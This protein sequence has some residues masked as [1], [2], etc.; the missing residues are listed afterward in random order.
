MRFVYKVLFLFL[1]AFH[2]RT[3]TGVNMRPDVWRHHA[4][5]RH[6]LT[7]LS[8]PDVGRLAQVNH[9]SRRAV[10]RALRAFR[11]R[12]ARL[13]LALWVRRHL[14]CEVQS[15]YQELETHTVSRSATGDARVPPRVVSV[16][17]ERGVVP[18][19]QAT[20]YRPEG[21]PRVLDAPGGLAVRF[22]CDDAAP[23]MLTNVEQRGRRIYSVL[24]LQLR[25]PS[26]EAE[27]QS[28][29]VPLRTL[30]YL[31]DSQEWRARLSAA[32]KT[33][34]ERHG[35]MC[36]F[37]LVTADGCIALELALPPRTDAMLDVYLVKRIAAMVSIQELLERAAVSPLM[38]LA[39]L[40]M[41]LERRP[42]M[43]VLTFTQLNGDS[44]S[45]SSSVRI[46][47]VLWMDNQQRQ[48]DEMT[49]DVASQRDRRETTGIERF[50]IVTFE[51]AITSEDKQPV[52]L[53]R[54]PGYV[55]LKMQD[56]SVGSSRIYTTV[57]LHNG[58][59]RQSASTVMIQASWVPGTLEFYPTLQSKQRRPLKGR[60]HMVAHLETNQVKELS[61]T[62]QHLAATRLERYAA[63][64]DSYYRPSAE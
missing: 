64:I 6:L 51:A 23:A 1:S 17:A 43:A 7:F 52:Q 49:R 38:K 8:A 39:P 11:Q 27:P 42:A 13:G 48:A 16:W 54:E 57:M 58:L 12:S 5:T 20:R 50:E 47:G 53:P 40:P 21:L 34:L 46:T 32:E 37:D 44:V 15:F 56:L 28:R 18:G 60:L 4:I 14:E 63:R 29:V 2:F 22:A 55:W 9:Q 24:S 3:N 62:A 25:V 36:R 33:R 61:I 59:Q 35:A 45:S 10:T 19:S 31:P 41:G 26:R 30:V